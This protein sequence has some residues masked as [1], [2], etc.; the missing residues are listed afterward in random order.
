[1]SEIELPLGFGMALV[2][3]EAAMRRFEALS[4][5]EKE[6][7]IRKTHNVRSK[8]EMRALVD[9]LLEHKDSFH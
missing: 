1:M 5:A 2:Q 3:N 7:M 9:S 8:Q 4:H 6:S